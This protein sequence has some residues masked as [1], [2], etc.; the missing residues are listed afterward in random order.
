MVT[1]A[2]DAGFNNQLRCPS[3][4]DSTQPTEFSKGEAAYKLQLNI[5]YLNGNKNEE[6]IRDI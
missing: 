1:I 2:G 5:G 3:D 6:L 4:G